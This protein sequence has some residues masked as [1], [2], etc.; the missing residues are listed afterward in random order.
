MTR[1]EHIA[2]AKRRAHEYLAAGDVANAVASM[3]SD[4]NKHP[5]CRVGQHLVM[6]GLLAAR[7]H[8]FVLAQQFIDGFR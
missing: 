5:E 4:M 6:L 3:I 1:D 7:D 2:W 8:D